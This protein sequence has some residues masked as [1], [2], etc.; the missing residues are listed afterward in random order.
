MKIKLKKSSIGLKPDQKRTLKAL[1]F[2]KT[3]QVIDVAE[4]PCVAGMITKV[5]KFVE[6]IK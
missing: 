3:N 2:R 5:E 4:N 1:G 6:V